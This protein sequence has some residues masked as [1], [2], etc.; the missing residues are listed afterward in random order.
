MWL[1]SGSW[2]ATV[3]VWATSDGECSISLELY[4]HESAVL[5]VAMDQSNRYVVAGGED[6]SVVV[7]QVDPKARTSQ[8]LFTKLISTSSR[9]PVTAVQWLPANE[10]GVSGDGFAD[11]KFICSTSDGLIVCLDITGRLYAAT[12]VEGVKTGSTASVGVKALCVDNRGLVWSGCDDDSVRV[13]NLQKGF[14]K[15]LLMHSHVHDEEVTAL[16][17]SSDGSLL[18]TGGGSG[19]VRV[20]S[21]E[22]R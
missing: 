18:V 4:D 19:D 13:W 11:E 1:V 5:C 22:C 8:V 12:R 21:V 3:K 6:G 10:S 14:L 15:E 2:D 16:S 9:R 17:L 7:W 20:W